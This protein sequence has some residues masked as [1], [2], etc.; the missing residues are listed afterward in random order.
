M[1]KITQLS[2]LIIM[3]FASLTMTSQ[4]CPPTDIPFSQDFENVTPPAIPDC[5]TIENAGNGNDWHTALITS[6]GFNSNVLEY[7][8][9]SN[10][11]ANAWYFTQ[12]INLTAGIDYEIT[13]LYGNVRADFA[14][15]L[16]VSYGAQAN[17]AAMTNELANYP[18]VSSA[19]ATDG[20]VTFSVDTD[21]VYYFGF[22]A[23]SDPDQFTL[24]LDNIAVQEASVCPKP[25]SLNVENVTDES[26]EFVWDA[27]GSEVEW[28][29]IYGDIGFD[30]TDTSQATIIQDSD[31]I[32]GET[33]NG[34]TALTMYD[35]YVR[36]ICD[37]SSSSDLA[38]PKTFS[39]SDVNNNICDAILLNIGD[40]CSGEAYS[41]VGAT[42]Q[43]GEPLASCFSNPFT[44][45]KTVWFKFVAP[46]GGSVT[47]TTDFPDS[48]LDTRIAVYGAPTDCLDFATLGQELGCNDDVSNSDFSSTL[49]IDGLTNGVTY[50][51]QV[52]TF[53]NAEGAFCMSVEA[54]LSVAENSFGT[55]RYY[56]NPTKDQLILNA[57]TAIEQIDVYN[58]LGQ[59][60]LNTKPNK[61]K[62]ELETSNWQSGVYIMKVRLDGKE[63]T[64]RIL[65]D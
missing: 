61:P 59:N 16:R 11:A 14:E 52:A 8:Y 13:Y 32:L 46:S 3:A 23:Y 42:R 12:G 35:F 56:P 49:N 64:F 34:L 31:G 50:Y 30:P 44:S 9:N 60:V 48:T 4:N 21:G 6:N 53:N 40:G 65:K 36:A 22:N 20:A 17:S 58:I 47:L 19:E 51:A 28:E 5:G 26:V 24:F 37:A 55:F 38:G 10:N 15:K 43:D 39:T 57:D 41:N 54:R 63:E 25:V 18:D 33:V 2:F 29:I 7:I 1:K 45:G 27:S 62:T